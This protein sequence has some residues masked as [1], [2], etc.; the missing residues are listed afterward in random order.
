MN[1]E[2]MK[3]DSIFEACNIRKA[4]DGESVML[5]S[6]IRKSFRDVAE[7]FDLDS[8]NCPSHPSN[9]TEEWVKSDIE[10]GKI[11]FVAETETPVGCVVYDKIDDEVCQLGRLAVLPDFRM[12]GIGARLVQA[13]EIEA[14]NSGL[15]KV[16][17]GIIA[18]H[19]S[20]K[21]WYLKLGYAEVKKARFSQLPFEVLFM[22]KTLF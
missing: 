4:S 3:T 13:V 16:D 21:Q 15:E 2:E 1:N 17:I 22:S 7:K 5:A 20:L 9:C 11:Y 10:K 19:T 12:K 6:L 14:K 8:R 18:A